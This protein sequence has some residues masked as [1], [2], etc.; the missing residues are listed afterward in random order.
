MRVS[1]NTPG[2]SIAHMWRL[3]SHRNTQNPS[4]YGS[5]KS[6]SQHRT[7]AGC[8]SVVTLANYGHIEE[9]EPAMFPKVLRYFL[10]EVRR[11]R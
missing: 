1:T 6:L 8:L 10:E 3:G 7:E 2:S 11:E 4:Q 5:P 9:P